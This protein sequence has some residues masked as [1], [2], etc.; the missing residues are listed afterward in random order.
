M[1]FHVTYTS[2]NK[3]SQFDTDEGTTVKDVF[4][5]VSDEITTAVN[6]TGDSPLPITLRIT[7]LVE[8]TKASSPRK[9]QIQHLD[10]GFGGRAKRPKVPKR[11]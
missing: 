7:E 3:E 1:K 2:A 10:D 4:V 6:V 8:Q 5:R 11:T 9:P